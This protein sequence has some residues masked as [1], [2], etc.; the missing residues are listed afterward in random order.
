MDFVALRVG[1]DRS[2]LMSLNRPK[3]RENNARTRGIAGK[4]L[5]PRDDAFELAVRKKKRERI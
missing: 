4:I 3:K 1:K 5:H 2:I